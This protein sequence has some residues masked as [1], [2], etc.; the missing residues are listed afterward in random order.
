[1]SPAQ[2]GVKKLVAVSAIPASTTEATRKN[3][4]RE[5]PEQIALEMVSCIQ[6]PV[7]FRKD[8]DE[9]QALIDS[10]REVNA[11]QP[12]YAK[13]L[14][15]T[16]RKTE[17]GAQKINGSPINGSPLETY[18]MVIGRLP[19]PGQAKEVLFLPRNLLIGRY[20]HGSSPGNALLY[21]QQCRGR[22]CRTGAYLEVLHH[23]RGLTK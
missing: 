20:Q 4:S 15:L 11:I 21:L 14:G 10:D 5:A 7:R 23:S 19:S 3:V 22:V 2:E 6:Y 18:G 16:I 1:M 12:A 13:K 9:T 17:V 8:Q